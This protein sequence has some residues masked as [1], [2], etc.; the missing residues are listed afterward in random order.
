VT[1]YGVTTIVALALAM[2]KVCVTSG[3]AL[4]VSSPPWCAVTEHDP[5]PVIW[6]VDPGTVQFPL[7]V[8]S[9]GS[10]E[11]DEALALKSVSP[12]LQSAIGLNAIVYGCLRI[13]NV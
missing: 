11:D 13:S 2:A 5:A 1:L 8:K 3:A 10:P 9:T 4:C 7:T 6:I 12:Y